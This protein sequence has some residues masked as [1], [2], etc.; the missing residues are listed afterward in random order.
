MAD[1]VFAGPSLPAAEAARLLPGARILPPIAHGDLL[2]LDPRPG[3]R[4]FI[5][6]GLFLQ[7]APVRHREILHLL[8][9][10]VTVAGSSSMGALRAAELWPFG[11]RGHGEIFRMYRDGE[12]TGDDEV[13]IVHGPAD[14]GSKALSEPLV[15]IRIALRAAA[16]AGAVTAEEAGRLVELARALPFR[17]RGYR[18]LRHRARDLGDGSAERFLAWLARNPSDAKAA[19]ARLMLRHAAAGP[20]PAPAPAPAAADL[21]IEHVGTSYF[22][23]WQARYGGA[24]HDGR[25]VTTAEVAG[26]LM[27]LHPGFPEYHR[28]D[29]LARVTGA[30][31]EDPGLV[32]AAVA[33]ARSHGLLGPVPPRDLPEPSWLTPAD[34]DLPDADAA[35]RV[36][37]RAFGTVE[38]RCIDQ[39]LI[40]AALSGPAVRDA[41]AG[42]VATA[43]ALNE[44]IP[45]VSPQQPLRRRKFKPDVIDAWFA[46]LWECAPADLEP[47]AWDRGFVNLHHFRIVAEPFVMYLKTFGRPAFP[48]TGRQPVSVG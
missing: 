44:S 22:T 34:R 37:V 9:R 10:G 47:A 40:P 25:F 28:R 14:E 15:N 12:V 4:V 27:L 26:A 30:G 13:A 1:I 24:E 45:R 20:A 43:A 7:A 42:I 5:V 17:L 46:R 48:A 8:E 3:D 18:A 11:M 36:M 39:R 21:P 41:A 23:G 38:H 32:E 35:L 29:V 2:R 19:D 33:V 6:D 16:A 31:P